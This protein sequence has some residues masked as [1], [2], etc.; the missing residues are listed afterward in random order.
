MGGEDAIRTQ[1]R[2]RFDEEIIPFGA[3]GGL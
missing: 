1:F 2:G 3:R